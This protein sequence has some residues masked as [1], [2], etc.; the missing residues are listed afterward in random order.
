[1]QYSNK[2]KEHF[3]FPIYLLIFYSQ[4]YLL[5]FKLRPIRRLYSLFSYSQDNVDILNSLFSLQIALPPPTRNQVTLPLVAFHSSPFSTLTVGAPQT[6]L[7]KTSSILHFCARIN[8]PKCTRA[9][10]DLGSAPNLSINARDINGHTCLFVAVLF[11]QSQTFEV[12]ASHP[13]HKPD[14]QTGHEGRLI[15]RGENSTLPAL[16]TIP[17]ACTLSCG[18]AALSP[19]SLSVLL[20]EFADVQ[21]PDQFGFTPLH[22]AT[23]YGQVDSISLLLRGK[24][25]SRQHSKQLAIID[26]TN[27]TSFSS[28]STSASAST[29]EVGINPKST[30]PAALCPKGS[31]PLHVLLRHLPSESG[32]KS[33]PSKMRRRIVGLQCLAEMLLCG[34][35]SSIPDARGYTVLHCMAMQKDVSVLRLLTDITN[36]RGGRLNLRAKTTAGVTLRASVENGN[37]AGEIAP[38]ATPFDIACTRNALEIMEA[39]VRQKV[40][41]ELYCA[42]VNVPSTSICSLETSMVL[43]TF[44]EQHMRTELSYVVE[45][46]M[47]KSLAADAVKISLQQV[48][49]LQNQIT[50]ASDSTLTPTDELKQLGEVTEEPENT[51]AV[52]GKPKAAA[53]DAKAKNET[54]IET[55]NKIEEALTSPSVE[56]SMLSN[57]HH[58]QREAIAMEELLEGV[59]DTMEDAPPDAPIVSLFHNPLIVPGKEFDVDYHLSFY[60]P[61][62]ENADIGVSEVDI[63]DFLEN[64]ATHARSSSSF[65]FSFSPSH[66]RAP[67][68]ARDA[69]S[70]HTVDSA[71]SAHTVT[72]METVAGAP[73]LPS[74]PSATPY[75]QNG[76]GKSYL[77]LAPHSFR[78]MSSFAVD[79]SQYGY[80]GGDSDTASFT[81]AG[82]NLISFPTSSTEAQDVVKDPHNQSLSRNNSSTP[83]TSRSAIV[84]AVT[85]TSNTTTSTST[86]SLDSPTPPTPRD[87]FLPGSRRSLSNFHTLSSA[88]ARLPGPTSTP[89]T[90]S[91]SRNILMGLDTTLSS[92]SSSIST[93]TG[94]RSVQQ[95]PVSTSGFDE[96]RNSQKKFERRLSAQSF[97]TLPSRINSQNDTLTS[98]HIAASI[99]VSIPMI[100]SDGFEAKLSRSSSGAILRRPSVSSSSMAK[101]QSLD[102]ISSSPDVASA[103]AFMH[104]EEG[105]PQSTGDAIV[106]EADLPLTASVVGSPRKSTR[107]KAQLERMLAELEQSADA[108]RQT[109]R[110]TE[111]ERDALR[112]A[113]TTAEA[114]Q[115]RKISELS[116]QYKRAVQE[117]E[118]AEKELTHQRQ[119]LASRDAQ[120]EELQHK[121]ASFE[122]ELE[123]VLA[124]V[125]VILQTQQEQQELL[126]AQALAQ[127]QSQANAFVQG[128]SSSD[129][130]QGGVYM[131]THG[132]PGRVMGQ[133]I[134]IPSAEEHPALVGSLSRS[135]SAQHFAQ[136]TQR[137]N[138]N[139]NA[140]S[141]SNVGTPVFSPSSGAS[142]PSGLSRS[143]S[144]HNR[145]AGKDLN[146]FSFADPVVGSGVLTGGPGSFKVSG[147]FSSSGIGCADGTFQGASGSLVG[148]QVGSMKLGAL[149][150]QMVGNQHSSS[151]GFEK[152]AKERL[153]GED[154]RSDQFP[155]DVMQMQHGKMIYV[156]PGTGSS[157]PMSGMPSDQSFVSGGV[158]ADEYERMEHG[159]INHTFEAGK[160]KEGKKAEKGGKGEKG[161][162]SE[163]DDKHDPK[164]KNCCCRCCCCC[165]IC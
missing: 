123:A 78:R 132:T 147:S 149:R 76:I 53:E 165:V 8:A 87:I 108:L 106:S 81:A 77:A 18:A 51:V 3:L 145:D 139:T 56:N 24:L 9:L 137:V 103:T 94:V 84:D 118:Q 125:T 97:N 146:S 69:K 128:H 45:V 120:V 59:L 138:A 19:I 115:T 50:S 28:T 90:P 48:Q 156:A 64:N 152:Q 44:I 11:D 36:A 129:R 141:I 35:S 143:L 111:L 29:V 85:S 117:R 4:S 163:D 80:T 42:T 93:P 1:M 67:S 162:K 58:Q 133:P 114:I 14:L 112:H 99:S 135:R 25:Q 38:G 119:C 60:L 10:L 88:A 16:F 122:Q 70:E 54:E 130:E 89:S 91:S 157:S 155:S 140:M 41:E 17:P 15:E 101:I 134:T 33:S 153:L 159:T 154:L 86:L 73:S 71:M 66:S 75:S 148:S 27:R 150:N 82:P 121:A 26:S 74:S 43:E 49:K 161:G 23:L 131:S 61:K 144:G 104:P 12:L 52:K 127:S 79:Y 46:S 57:L 5:A 37:K 105:L 22:Y 34:A 151:P 68:L 32:A 31:T 158:S 62:L 110:T 142:L 95:L 55:E 47:V 102:V 20:R 92:S 98:G 7:P 96:I 107:N 39:L 65:S 124:E 63:G 21:S 116:E 164:N 2:L 136:L 83:L 6:F 113:A 109:L 126:Q 160:G 30:A 13:W 40:V 100:T 72:Q